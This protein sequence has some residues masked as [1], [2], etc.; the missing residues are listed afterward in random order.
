MNRVLPA[1]PH[2]CAGSHLARREVLIATEEWHTLIPDFE[3]DIT[4]P[5]VEHG[6]QLG[7][8]ALPLRWS[9]QR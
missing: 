1:A 3:I 4:E 5:L 2:R 7:L 9:R 8:D 6:W